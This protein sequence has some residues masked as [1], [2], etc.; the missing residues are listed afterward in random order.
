MSELATTA[1]VTG[2]SRGIGRAVAQT[3]AREGYQVFLTYV[4][5]PEDAEAT[6]SSIRADG[7]KARAFHLDTGDPQA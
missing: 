6:C 2:G 1:L 5:R 7:G 3:L 4:S